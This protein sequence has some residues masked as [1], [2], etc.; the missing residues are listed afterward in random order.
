VTI[1]IPEKVSDLENDKFYATETFVTNKIAEA[2]LAGG[3]VDLS[4]YAT[5]DDLLSKVDK[6]EKHSLVADSE[7]ER[8]S[9]VFNYD[10]T[11]IK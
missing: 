2:E 3:D 9:K 6:I 10:D 11:E 8:L 1:S 4:G 7:I 5:K